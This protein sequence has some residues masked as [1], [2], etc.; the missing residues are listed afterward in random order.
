M[1]FWIGP[2][3]I[4]LCSLV[5][6]T[7]SICLYSKVSHSNFFLHFLIIMFF[8]N[9][10]T[11]GPMDLSDFHGAKR[12]RVFDFPGMDISPSQVI[13]QR[14]PVPDSSGWTEKT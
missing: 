10:D 12:M 13:S 4:K 7:T 6:F 9:F 3:I 1:I 2:R 8:N 11:M 14:K 5:Y